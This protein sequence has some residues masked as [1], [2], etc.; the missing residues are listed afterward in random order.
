MKHRSRLRLG[1]SLTAFAV[2]VTACG[3]TDETVEADPAA[4]PA[5][6]TFTIGVSNTLVG[7]GWR[8]QMICAAKA[9]ALASGVVDEVVVVNRNGGPTEQIAD[10]E[11]L[12]SQGVDAIILNPT[13]REALNSVLEAAIEQGI[14]IVAVDMAVTAEGAYV[15]TNDQVA[16]GR[17]G[18][19]WL[20]EQLGG[21][22]GIVEMRGIDGVPADTDRHDG[23]LEAFADNPGMSIVAETFTGWD[24]STGAQQALDLITTRTDI[25]GIWTTGID[26]TVVEQF[27]AANKP[28]VPIAGADNNG[29]IKQLIELKDEGLIGAA[30]TNP[31]AIGGVGVAVAIRVLKGE[32]LDNEILLTPQVYDNVTGIAELEAIYL[33]DMQ[34]GWSSYVEIEPWTTYS[35][36]MVA[37]CKG[38]G[39]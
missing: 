23:V 13:D 28:F 18:A 9:E 12:I 29:F 34:P 31:P 21:E 16:Y 36:D 32:S 3:G 6:A 26:Y 15:V 25:D 35:G 17:L 27:E 8:E 10:L 22:G 4:T 2:L 5:D 19:E 30:V 11:N 33:P 7:N 39:E 37:A 24:P 14:V 20:A 38:P 1:A